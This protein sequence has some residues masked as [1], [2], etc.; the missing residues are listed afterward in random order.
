MK[1]LAAEIEPDLWEKLD[2][3][4]GGSESLDLS[5]TG[6][7]IATKGVARWVVKSYDGAHELRVTKTVP[8]K[9]FGRLLVPTHIS[10]LASHRTAATDLWPASRSMLRL[11]F[12]AGQ[13]ALTLTGRY[14]QG[15]A[16]EGELPDRGEWQRVAND[17]EDP[18]LIV[19]SLRETLRQVGVLSVE[20]AA[21]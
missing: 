15:D 18:E 13:G 17:L 4:Y 3:S 21:A 14:L 11:E 19:T 8:A 10:A 1:I 2:A 12:D 16:E 7:S 9:R 6:V 20:A 5:Q